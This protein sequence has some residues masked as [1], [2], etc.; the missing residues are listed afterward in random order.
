MS[1]AEIEIQKF[2]RESGDVNKVFYQAMEEVIY[3]IAP[4]LESD[5]NIVNMGF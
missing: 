2:E 5:Q 1:I 4:L 3:S